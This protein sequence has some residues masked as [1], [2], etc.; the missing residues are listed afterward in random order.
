[1]SGPEYPNLPDASDDEDEFEVSS[2]RAGA[3]STSS[4]LWARSCRQILSRADAEGSSP[5]WS[6]PDCWCWFGWV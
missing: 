1:M 4:S 6:P 3:G 2:L 5:L